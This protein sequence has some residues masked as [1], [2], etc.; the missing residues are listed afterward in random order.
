MSFRSVLQRFPRVSSLMNRLLRRS[1]SRIQLIPV[2]QPHQIFELPARLS[3]REIFL[4]KYSCSCCKTKNEEILL[5]GGVF[6]LVQA[7]SFTLRVSG[8]VK[9]ALLIILTCFGGLNLSYL[10]LHFYLKFVTGKR[11]HALHKKE[12]NFFLKSFQLS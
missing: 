1:T 11:A 8:W 5:G 10:V 7:K 4:L 9:D 2:R 6:Y 3:E 12:F